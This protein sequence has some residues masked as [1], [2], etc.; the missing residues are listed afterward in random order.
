MQASDFSVSVHS[1]KLS[2]E[3][4]VGDGSKVVH[5]VDVHQRVG[6]D[7]GD[8]HCQESV[9]SMIKKLWRPALIGYLILFIGFGIAFEIGA[10]ARNEAK[11]QGCLSIVEAYDLVADVVD[12]AIPP[13]PEKQPELD[14]ALPPS[15]RDLIEKS[16]QQGVNIRHRF[17]IRL[18][19]PI[20]LCEAVGIHRKIEL[21][22]GHD[23]RITYQSLPVPTVVIERL[24]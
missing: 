7:H 19:N 9:V 13:V 20:P 10:R 2:I 5:P 21:G 1:F 22:K 17:E 6:N 4:G 16:R 12:I 14:P 23:T 11:R 18:K 15:V 8:Q 3:K 24:S